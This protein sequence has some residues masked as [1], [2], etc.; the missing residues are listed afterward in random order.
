MAPL[1]PVSLL[2]SATLRLA[3][4][5]APRCQPVQA[6]LA[7]QDYGSGK[8]NPAS[9]KPQL[10]GKT[11]RENLECPGSPPPKVAHSQWSHSPNATQY[12][13]SSGR[14]PS[15]TSPSSSEES[16]KSAVSRGQQSRPND[17]ATKQG[18][19][20][21]EDEQSIK[22][23]QSKIQDDNPPTGNRNEDVRQHNAEM[24]QRAERAHE[25]GVR[26]SKFSQ[27][28]EEGCVAGAGRPSSPPGEANPMDWYTIHFTKQFV[29]Y[30][31][32]MKDEEDI[33][34]DSSGV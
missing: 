18:S 13:P 29:R 12:P 7:H 19:R 30:F 11:P 10:Q 16:N 20:N 2:R 27:C 9:E 4:R 5:V 21:E 28:S 25:Q 24:E 34:L 6:R 23:A 14:S 32:P 1:R 26:A 33:F 17:G 15:Q 31:L 3:G 8:G 22:G